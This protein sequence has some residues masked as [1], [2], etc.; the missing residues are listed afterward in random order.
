MAL[1]AAALVV[2]LV[3]CSKPLLDVH[4]H[5]I[6]NVL[7][8]DREIIFDLNVH[9]RNPNLV[10]I[11]VSDADLLVHAK[12]KYVGTSKFWREHGARRP[13]I[14]DGTTDSPVRSAGNVDEGTDPIDD[15]DPHVM[16]LGQIGEFDTPLIFEASPVLHHEGRLGRRG[17]AGAPGQRDRERRLRPLGD[18]H[19]A[20]VR[21]D[22]ERGGPL[23]DPDQLKGK[24]RERERERHGV[25]G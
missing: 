23:P 13:T 2:A 21:T 22:C 14:T 1:L 20:S 7:A 8:A 9:A 12:S 11:Q 15:A 4:V 24:E 19:P 16:L 18:G 17:A 5:D 3:F 25:S 6:R 10:S